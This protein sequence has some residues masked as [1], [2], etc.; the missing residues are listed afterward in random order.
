MSR[1]SLAPSV[2]AVAN[3][4][5]IEMMLLKAMPV[6]VSRRMRALLSSIDRELIKPVD[7]EIADIFTADQ[8]VERE[9]PALWGLPG[10]SELAQ[11]YL[12]A[13]LLADQA[14]SVI[15]DFA[16]SSLGEGTSSSDQS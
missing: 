13:A 4:I 6:S 9:V 5:A 16:H 8:V 15:A 11:R 3:M 10:L 7:L 12:P 2:A 1:I 14:I